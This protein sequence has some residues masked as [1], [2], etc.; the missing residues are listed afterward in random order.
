MALLLTAGA[1]VA[2]SE[3]AAPAHRVLFVGNSLTYVNDLPGMVAAL[4]RRGG[5][6]PALETEIVAFGNVSLEDHWARKEALRAIERGGW[7]EVVLQQ[8]PSSLPENRALLVSWTKRFAKRIRAVGA[9]PALYMVW[10]SAP[11]SAD[12]PRVVDAYAA[13][14]KTVDGLLLPV[15]DA[16]RA[17]WRRDPELA[18]YGPDGFHPSPLGTYLAAIVIEAA[19]TDAPAARRA[20]RDRAAGRRTLRISAERAAS[21]RRPPPKRSRASGDVRTHVRLPDRPDA[22]ER[23][24]LASMRT[25]EGDAP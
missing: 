8:G 10:P 18:L 5:A 23:P 13:A 4:S 14:A 16:W 22:D 17:A 25:G 9:R 15:G 7:T 12:F 1:A 20:G 11:R 21:S 19:L 2:G 6:V 24:F 3:E